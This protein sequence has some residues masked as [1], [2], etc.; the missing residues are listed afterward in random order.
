MTQAL[1]KAVMDSNPSVHQGDN[2]PVENVTWDECEVFLWQLNELTGKKFRLPTMAEWEYAARGGNKSKGYKYSGSNN[3]DDVAWY[4][5]NSNGQSHTIKAKHPNE[6]GLYDMSGN[7][8][9]W[10]EDR[11]VD[12][13]RIYRRCRDGSWKKEATRCRVSARDMEK[14]NY[15]SSDL[16]LRLAH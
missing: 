14:E 1:W 16:G 8:G 5:A 9:E 15:R 2:L 4:T 7:V 3:V 12:L 13:S 10:C 6:L 11:Y